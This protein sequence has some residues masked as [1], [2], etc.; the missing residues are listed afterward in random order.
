MSH[1]LAQASGLPATGIVVGASAFTYQ[2][3]LAQPVTVL[4]SGGTV[5]TIEI[6]RDGSTFFLVGLLA[7]QFRLSPNDKLR[8]TYAVAPTM[9]MVPI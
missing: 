3:T 1:G 4:V 5:T 2:N 8:V 6:S 7:G 9:T